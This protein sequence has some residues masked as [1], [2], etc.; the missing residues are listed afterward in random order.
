MFMCVIIFHPSLVSDISTDLGM[1]GFFIIAPST[2][3][4][5]TFSV[6][7]VQRCC[8][9]E[10]SNES[11]RESSRRSRCIEYRLNLIELTI[12]NVFNFNIPFMVTLYQ[13]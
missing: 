9:I 3:P 5:V 4:N 6:H 2:Y 13:F 1:F 7:R 12:K 11:V 10:V 8:S